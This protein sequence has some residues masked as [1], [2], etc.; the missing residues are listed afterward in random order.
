MGWV[1]GRPEAPPQPTTEQ[2]SRSSKRNPV[3]CSGAASAGFLLV[4]AHLVVAYFN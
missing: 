2:R 3:T 4:R 1:G